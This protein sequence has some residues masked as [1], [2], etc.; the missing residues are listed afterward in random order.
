MFPQQ[1]AIAERWGFVYKTMGV[2]NKT[3]SAGKQ[4]FGTGYILRTS[5]EPFIIATRGEPKTS[6]SVRSSFAAVRRE[7]SRKPEMAYQI[8]EKL[9]PKGRRVEIFSR[10]NRA[11][12]SVWGDEVGKFDG[13][14]PPDPAFKPREKYQNQL[15]FFDAA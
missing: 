10:A 15:P 5:H 12:W 6:R 14:A 9:L 7:H 2:W 8:A 3:T 1:V 11:G 13:E 4:A